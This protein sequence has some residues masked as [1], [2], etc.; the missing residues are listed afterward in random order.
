M[1]LSLSLPLPSVFLGFGGTP[2]FFLADAPPPPSPP[3]STST[4]SCVAPQWLLVDDVT[5][6]KT[7]RSLARWLWMLFL[8]AL[9]LEGT[10]LC[11]SQSGVAPCWWFLVAL[12]HRGAAEE[13]LQLSLF[14]RRVPVLFSFFFLDV[15]VLPPPS[16]RSLARC[17]SF[18]ARPPSLRALHTHTY[19]HT[20]AHASS[21]T[22]YCSSAAAADP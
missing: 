10:R 18:A 2:L 5:L 4:P 15:I 7:T 19:T 21:A 12:S 6:I 3:P 9:R 20:R 16:L 8:A 11:S 13:L 22:R 17:V 1:G 14:H